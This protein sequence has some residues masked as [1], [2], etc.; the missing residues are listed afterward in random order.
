M[1]ISALEVCM[2][3]GYRLLAFVVVFMSVCT[4]FAQHPESA[5]Q[6]RREA[7]RES[8]QA[9]LHQSKAVADVQADMVQARQG[10]LAAKDKVYRAGNEWGGH[11]MN[12]LKDIN[13]ALAEIDKAEA[14]AK[15]HH[16][17]R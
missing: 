12:A 3:G 13:A 4:G 11:R 14:Y 8:A 2:S 7:Q 10:L 15:A 5:A 6:E 9:R 17:V 16:Y 1:K